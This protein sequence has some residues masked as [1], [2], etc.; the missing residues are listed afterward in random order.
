MEALPA[1]RSERL[2][3]NIIVCTF[4]PALLRIKFCTQ[5]DSRQ[6]AVV[7]GLDN[8][9]QKTVDRQTQA[10]SKRKRTRMKTHIQLKQSRPINS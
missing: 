8:N 7:S 6:S 3:E 10:A 9:K 1:E 2:E 5:A 4:R